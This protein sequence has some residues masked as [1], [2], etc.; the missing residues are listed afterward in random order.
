MN[1]FFGFEPIIAQ[2]INFHFNLNHLF[3]GLAVIAVICGLYFA[4]CARSRTGIRLTKLLLAFA[5]F[6]LET[7]RVVWLVLYFRHNDVIIDGPMIWRLV[8]FSF[9]GVMSI[10]T[11]IVLMISALN[12]NHNGPGMQIFY[13]IVFALGTVGGVMTFAVP[14]I[15]DQRFPIVHF[16]NFQTIA[17]HLLLI[18][19]PLYLVKIRE[20]KPRIKN[21]WMPLLGF[22][23]VGSINMA[24]SQITGKN[25]GFM[26]YIEDL[27]RYVDFAIPF[28][29]H[30][31]VFFGVVFIGIVIPYYL[32]FEI[33]YQIKKRKSG[34]TRYPRPLENGK[35]S[36][37]CPPAGQ[38]HPPPKLFIFG[39]G[40]CITISGVS[41]FMIPFML[42]TFYKSPVE[43]WL[44][45]VC[46]APLVTMTIGIS[47]AYLVKY[48]ATRP[49]LCV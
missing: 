22:I 14:E 21:L 37:F 30:A 42:D 17:V 6:A 25:R 11:G 43:S 44:G 38:R 4:L 33:V 12:R 5:F 2:E 28:P 32:G 18:L 34:I 36:C 48:L 45:L 35:L 10:T 7:G 40:L 19:V 29:W 20:L 27:D 1:Y 31:L 26:L 39:I 15:F 41:L 9:C 46:L 49:K 47:F 8:P 13:N 24:A 23:G 3:I 16:R